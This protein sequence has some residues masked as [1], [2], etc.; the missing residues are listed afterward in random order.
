MRLIAKVYVH[1]GPQLDIGQGETWYV[2]RT[3]L[4][5]VLAGLFWLREWVPTAGAPNN[6]TS[7]SAYSRGLGENPYVGL[8][9]GLGLAVRQV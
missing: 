2:G 3:G 7:A 8:G 1:L 6:T 9:A 5:R 4:T